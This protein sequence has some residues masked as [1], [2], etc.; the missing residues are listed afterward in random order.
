[1]IR[2]LKDIIINGSGK[3]PILLDVTFNSDYNPKK[4]IIFCHGFKGFKDWGP[5]NELADY[6][7]LQGFV[8]V[9]FNFSYNGTTVK[10][11]LEFKDLDSFGNNNF[12]IELDDLGLVIDWVM[13]SQ[14]LYKEIN[15]NQI[16]LFV[17]I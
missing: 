2:K 17:N 16:I 8:F 4:I 14:E 13:Q 6:F 7:A 10:K 12:C 5:F 3:N 11:P 9:K 15:K 1:M